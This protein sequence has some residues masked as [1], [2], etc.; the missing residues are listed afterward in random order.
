MAFELDHRVNYL[1]QSLLAKKIVDIHT[2]VLSNSM[3]SILSL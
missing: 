3:R 1:I 2:V